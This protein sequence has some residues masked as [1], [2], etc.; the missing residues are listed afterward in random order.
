MSGKEPSSTLFPLLF[1]FSFQT[2]PRP[3]HLHSDFTAPLLAAPVLPSKSS[4]ASRVSHPPP[5]P[6]V[7]G[8]LAVVLNSHW[9]D[10]KGMGPHEPGKM[11]ALIWE[12]SQP[13]E[14]HPLI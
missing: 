5:G 2:D 11:V 3:P 13:E 6:G 12:K 8:T 10:M 9:H 7:L 14:M 1:Q 4:S